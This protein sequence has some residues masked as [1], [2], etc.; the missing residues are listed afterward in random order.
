MNLAEVWHESRYRK[1]YPGGLV[2]APPG[3]EIPAKDDQYNLWKGFTVLPTETG[4]WSMFREHLLNV[5]CRGNVSHYDWF[6]RWW[7]A[8]LQMP[9]RK[10]G[11]SLAVRGG[12]GS[13]KT[14]IAYMFRQIF[15]PYFFV[16]MSEEEFMG[17]FTDQLETTLIVNSE[18]AFWAKSR[19]AES[20]LKNLITSQV[21]HINKKFVP[22][23]M[24]RNLF[25]LFVT[26]NAEHVVPASADERRWAVFEMMDGYLMPKS[27][28][29]SMKAQMETGGYGR[30]LYDL[31]RL[32]LSLWDVTVIPDTGGLRKQKY[33]GAKPEERVVF[34]AAAEGRVHGLRTSSAGNVVWDM[35]YFREKYENE[36]KFLRATPEDQRIVGS[37]L[38]KMGFRST[39]ASGGRRYYIAP[40]LM[41]LRS[42]LDAH[43][44][45]RWTWNADVTGWS[46][47]YIEYIGGLGRSGLADAP[48]APIGN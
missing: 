46:S 32:D 15:G 2:F 31:V 14:A 4:D 34:E 47:G 5:V 44:S 12:K 37:F 20:K 25:D 6:I 28:W 17:S 13:G 33:L 1:W 38:V 30:M 36:C 21:V 10:N 16:A 29:E 43:F 26:S 23:Y 11:V 45:T 48:D 42:A 7:A 41:E 35:E 9:G 39:K 18:E 8:R 3:A 40:D 27:Q 24:A 19:K 22:A